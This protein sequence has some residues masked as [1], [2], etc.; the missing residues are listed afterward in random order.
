MVNKLVDIISIRLYFYIYSV[1]FNFEKDRHRCDFCHE[2]PGCPE[3]YGQTN[4]CL[5]CR[6]YW[7]YDIEQLEKKKHFPLRLISF[8]E[9]VKTDL[10]NTAVMILFSS[11]GNTKLAI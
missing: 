9:E 1:F 2:T 3:K 8:Y 4:Y 6:F 5:V 10:F 11:S 7:K